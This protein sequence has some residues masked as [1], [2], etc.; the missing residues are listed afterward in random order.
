M[1]RRH[2][3]RSTRR[4]VLASG[5]CLAIAVAFG[6][7]ASGTSAAAASTAQLTS[8]A[9]AT[10]ASAPQ[11]TS[12]QIGSQKHVYYPAPDGRLE[13]RWTDVNTWRH[14][15]IGGAVIEGRPAAT[16]EAD[17]YARSTAGYLQHWWFDYVAFAWRHEQLD[18]APIA[19]SPDVVEH[20]NGSQHVWARGTNG[21][22][23]HWWWSQGSGWNHQDM[24]GP[25]ISG[26]PS[27]S[28]EDV[29]ARSTTGY[30][31]HWWWTGSAWQHEQLGHAPI[32][33][34]PDVVEHYD[35]GWHVWARGA[36]GRL[37]HWW[38]TSSAGWSHQD[39]G[40]PN[41]QGIP[42]GTFNSDV[43]AT[44]ANGYVQHWWWHEGIWLHEQLGPFITSPSPSALAYD[45]WEHYVFFFR[46]NGTPAYL[47]WDGSWTA[48]TF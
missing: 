15:Y 43:Y 9:S 26:I 6:A 24:G 11:M 18:H 45:S 16:S 3:T 32:A 39:M 14:E 29:Y 25:S 40:G 34:S 5:A 37:Q 19:G 48:H 13:H 30:L 23:Q 42:S 41:I 38:W 33:D 47:Q 7:I 4:H 17:V 8:G 31:Q 27:G 44:G 36:N 20:W 1:H 22:L 21:R 46:T 35:G 28:F 10:A 12:V 2:S